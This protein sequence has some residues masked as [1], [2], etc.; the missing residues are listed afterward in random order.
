MRELFIVPISLHIF[1]WILFLSFFLFSSLFSVIHSVL[2]A[3]SCLSHCIIFH[4]RTC[5]A[6]K[7]RKQREEVGHEESTTHWNRQSLHLTNWTNGFTQNKFYIFIFSDRFLGGFFPAMVIW[8]IFWMFI[9]LR[10][11]WDFIP[12]RRKERIKYLRFSH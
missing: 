1:S 3:F 7:K 9:R 4:I 12:S 8:N 10:V 2:T 6:D 11:F 5:R